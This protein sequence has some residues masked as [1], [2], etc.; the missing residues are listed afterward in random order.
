MNRHAGAPNDSAHP[1]LPALLQSSD[2]LRAGFIDGLERLL[3]RDSLGA[4]ILVH[5]NA[6]IDPGLWPDFE[7]RLAERRDAALAA[8]AAGAAWPGSADDRAVFSTLSRQASEFAVCQRTRE[9]GP[10]RICV[11]PMR[12]LRPARAAE[13]PVHQLRAPFNPDGFHF[14]R[15]F[16]QPE[17]LWQ[18]V[19]AGRETGLLYNKFPFVPLHGLLV[20]TPTAGREQ[21]LRED[22]LGWLV[23]LAGTLAVRIPGF[24]IA[25]NA[26]GASA[27]VNQLHLQ[28]FA[29]DAALAIESPT[30]RHNGGA[31]AYPV[32]V[33]T[34]VDADTAWSAIEALHAR[35]RPYH[36]VLRNA[37]IYLIERAFQGRFEAPV[38]SSGLAWH[39]FAGGFT[40]ESATAFAAMQPAELYEALEAAR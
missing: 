39:E 19:L 22:D 18:G 10:W 12:A 34:F 27:S 30:W 8:E 5:A 28:T 14:A 9:C 29:S 38:W 3:A 2:A 17:I 4:L 40:T 16:L 37:R 7:P 33:E 36:L 32:R 21:F 13:Q 6:A 31:D 15:P 25:Y 24:G 23:T 11:N 26:Y 35:E 1:A 20:P